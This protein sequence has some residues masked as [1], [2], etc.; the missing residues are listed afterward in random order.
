MSKSLQYLLKYFLC[1]IS[2][3]FM[4]GFSIAFGYACLVEALNGNWMV[5]SRLMGQDL[6]YNCYFKLSPGVLLEALIVGL[7]ASLVAFFL[8]MAGVKR[9]AAM[10]SESSQQD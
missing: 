10:L 8:M 5:C 1:L 7:V 6:I 3:P 9:T 2:F 4:A